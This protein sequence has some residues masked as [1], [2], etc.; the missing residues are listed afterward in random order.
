M[1][2]KPKDK[3]DDGKKTGVIYQIPCDDCSTV[4]IGETKRALETRVSE[5][6][7]NVRLGHMEKSA[8]SEHANRLNHSVNW[9]GVSILKNESRWHQRKWLE[10]VLIAKKNKE[11]V[12]SNRD[13]GRTL[14]DSYIQLLKIV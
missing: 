12:L 9:N 5:H 11:T 13:A 4:Y 14:P 6:E 1:I 3:L 8:L 2:S 7:R 10:A